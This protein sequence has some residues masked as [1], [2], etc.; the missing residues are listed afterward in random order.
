[1]RALLNVVLLVGLISVIAISWDKPLR[2]RAAEI[3]LVSQYVSSSSGDALH[4]QR[5]VHVG[6]RQQPQAAPQSNGAWMWDPNHKT[7][8]DRPA[9]NATHSFSGHVY[10]VDSNGA[11]YWLDAQGQRHYEP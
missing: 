10:Y 4:A 8:L 1:M 7:A 9:Y 3:P 6:G 5:A 2:E 11:K